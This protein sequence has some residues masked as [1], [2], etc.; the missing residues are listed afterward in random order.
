MTNVC[1]GIIA[2][3]TP[4][5]TPNIWI[6]NPFVSAVFVMHTAVVSTSP[7]GL[8]RGHSEVIKTRAL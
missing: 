4:N 3:I 6:K 7:W 1:S 2:N 5:I 8:M